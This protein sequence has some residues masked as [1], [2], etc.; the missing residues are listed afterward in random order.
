M[1]PRPSWESM[2]AGS[3]DATT[4][5]FSH[6]PHL[7]PL[8]T[9]SVSVLRLSAQLTAVGSNGVT[10]GDRIDTWIIH[11]IIYSEAEL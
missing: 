9:L 4:A 10:K 3:F 7:F 6:S 2:A 8:F 11:L 5:V 1:Q